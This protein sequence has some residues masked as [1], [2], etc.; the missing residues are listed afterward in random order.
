L[1]PLLVVVAILLSPSLLLMHGASGSIPH[2]FSHA[3][4]AYTLMIARGLR[5]GMPPVDLSW[6]GAPIRYHLGTPLL[7]D[8]FS[9]L[10]FLPVHTIYYSVIPILLKLI[11]IAAVLE[12]ARHIAPEL[13]PKVR[14]WIPLAVSGLFTVDFYNLAWH[15]HDVLRHGAAAFSSKG[16][17][18]FALHDGLFT[19]PAFDS[20]WLAVPFIVIL[21]ATL[22]TTTVFEQ[23]CLL[24]S[25]FLVK[26]QVFLAA[27]AGWG[28]FALLELR[29]REW[30]PLVVGALALGAAI[31]VLPMESTY[32]SMTH[33]TLGCGAECHRLLDQHGL[34]AKLPPSV[35]LPMEIFIFVIGFHIFALAFVRLRKSSAEGRLA[36]LIAIAGFA[37]AFSLK[38]LAA[39]ILRARF[40]AVYAPIAHAL[41]NPLPVYLDR[42]FDI[43]VD[44]AF[45]A[46]IRIVPLVAIP[47]L[48]RAPLRRTAAVVLAITVALSI[49]NSS[50]LGARVQLAQ[51]KEIAPDAMATL[52]AIP[53]GAH[54]ILTNDLAYDDHVER[55]LPLLNIWAPLASGQQFWA[56]AFMF[57]FQL[58]DAATRLHDVTWFFETASD[59]ERI[60]FA[61]AVGIDMVIARGA[62]RGSW[63]GWNLLARHGEYALYLRAVR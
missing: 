18:L 39:P 42:I 9:R 23:A 45:D 55:H 4:D 11:L 10:T 6:A 57:N 2:W 44:S 60:R 3:D 31:V 24:F 62:V 59:D 33:L 14:V 13:S 30:R 37:L 47:L 26:P 36:T 41:F 54:L 5:Y 17:P 51:A 15:A 35:V 25:I 48:A 61:R 40:F 19:Q 63:S 7:V 43:S 29:R 28:V 50:I 56:S 32:G 38:L 16:M 21:L 52:R 27:G 53:P 49:W 8:L 20:G 1:I 34:I 58:A 12:L 46:F 22:R